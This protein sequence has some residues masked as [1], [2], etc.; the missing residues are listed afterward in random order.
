LK[1]KDSH[2]RKKIKKRF[3]PMK[4][5]NWVIEKLPDKEIWIELERWIW[6]DLKRIKEKRDEKC[7]GVRVKKGHT[8]L[9]HW[10]KE[11]RERGY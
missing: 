3:V 8:L 7:D 10:K 1:G 11:V 5:M 4:R 6:S 2:R 9:I